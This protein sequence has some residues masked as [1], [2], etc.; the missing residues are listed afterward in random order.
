MKVS[1][2]TESE[3]T[4]NVDEDSQMLYVSV[5]KVVTGKPVTVKITV[6]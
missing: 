2:D 3:V 4:H 5:T 6:N 1:I